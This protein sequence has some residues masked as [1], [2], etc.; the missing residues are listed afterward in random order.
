MNE[1][2]IFPGVFICS[3]D[4]AC[5]VH[6][7]DLEGEVVTWTFDEI[8]ECP[9]TFEAALVAVGLAVLKGPKAVRENISDKGATLHE[10]YIQTQGHQNE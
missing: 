3:D 4:N 6:I 7:V 8:C 10:I 1:D 5:D 9:K 2:E